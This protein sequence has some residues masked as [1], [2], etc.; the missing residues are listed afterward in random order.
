LSR[1]RPHEVARSQGSRRNSWNKWL[2]STAVLNITELEFQREAGK[3]TGRVM[4]LIAPMLSPVS[5]DFA[6]I[7]LAVQS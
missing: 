6:S 4:A 5:R 7:K 1:R 2:E 3:I